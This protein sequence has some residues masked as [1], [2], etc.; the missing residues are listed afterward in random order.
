MTTVPEEHESA[1]EAERRRVFEDAQHEADT[2][3]AQYQ[4]SQLL[5]LGGD[6]PVM[7]SSVISELVRDGNAVWGALWLA[8][9]GEGILELVAQEPGGRAEAGDGG[10]S[11]TQA[12]RPEVVPTRF[13]G[14][15]AAEDW[16]RRNGWRGV[17]LDERRDLGEGTIDARIVGFLALRPPDGGELPPDGIRLLA[18]VRHE[19][20]I[21]FR[22]AQLREALARE[23][24][25]LAAILDGVNDA[26]VAVDDRRQVVRVNPAAATLLGGPRARQRTLTC[27]ELLGCGPVRAADG[28]G[29]ERLRC[30]PGCRFEEVISGRSRLVECEQVVL[31]RDGREVPVAAAYSYMPGPRPGAVAVLRDLRADRS[32][33]ELRG[34]FLAAVSHDLR[35]P[36]SLIT[37]YVDSLLALDLD[38]AEQRRSVERIGHAAARLAE[39]V[40]ELLDLTHFESSALGLQRSRMHLSAVVTRLASDLGES[41][42]MRPVHVAVPSDLPQVEIDAIRI[43]HVLSN[44]V[45]NAQKYGGDGPI[46]VSARRDRSQVIVTV[47]DRGGGIT[48]DERT[49]VFDRFYRGRDARSGTQGSGLGLYVCRRLVEAHGG[50]IWVESET[51]GSAISFSL[52]IAATGQTSRKAGA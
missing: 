23:Q 30:G 47:H 33:E 13:A 2:V 36:L 40:E 6:L 4:L 50:R 3:F 8:A 44:L 9:P 51:S 26:I 21:A 7:A 35:T 15:G 20:A 11:R 31:A 19:L 39:L 17:T 46:T 16:T 12:G 18:L 45:D 43:G 22:G 41:P 32:V 48:P 34:S 5:A 10:V 38:P 52:P 25:L 1:L 37:G 14:A 49:K 24:A 27:R 28:A 29:E 42:G